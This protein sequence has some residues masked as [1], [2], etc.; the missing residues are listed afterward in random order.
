MW[1]NFAEALFPSATAFLGVL[2][3]AYL[4]RKTTERDTRVRMLAE[5]YAEVLTNYG[6]FVLDIHNQ[7]QLT[8]LLSSIDKA[9]LV[10]PKGTNEHLIAL[11][12]A[13]LEK[14]DDEDAKLLARFRN[15]A[16]EDVGGVKQKRHR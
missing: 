11:R 2:I 5:F 3:G 6:K 1:L 12:T 13:L 8:C 14:R 10:C 7:E 16:A 9:R 4:A 15:S